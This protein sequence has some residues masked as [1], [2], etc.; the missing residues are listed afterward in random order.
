MLSAALAGCSTQEGQAGQALCLAVDA[1]ESIASAVVDEAS[2]TVTVGD[3]EQAMQA[4][5]TAYE[6]LAGDIR[7]AAPSVAQ[8]FEEAQAALSDALA[9]AQDPAT[10]DQAGERVDSARENLRETYTELV[11]AMGC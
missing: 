9:D 1:M 6:Q 3:A 4:L 7:N 5:S 10:L 11:D 8:Q 2:S